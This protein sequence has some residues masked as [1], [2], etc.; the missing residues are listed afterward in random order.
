MFLCPKTPGGTHPN[1]AIS[2]WARCHLTSPCCVPVLATR[3]G[4]S[5]LSCGGATQPV[6]GRWCVSGLWGRDSYNTGS[7]SKTSLESALV[8]GGSKPQGPI[9]LENKTEENR[10]PPVKETQATPNATKAHGTPR[11]GLV[12]AVLW[13]PRPVQGTQS[14]QTKARLPLPCPPASGRT[15]RG[16]E[17]RV[18]RSPTSL[19]PAETNWGHLQVRPHHPP[20]LLP[21]TLLG[22][23]FG[24]G[25]RC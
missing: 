2:C 23:D 15:H 21:N 3:T 17:D 11:V 19:P 12:G 13:R 14:C 10:R 8:G 7:F 25:V 16:Q 20:L 5:R 9:R 6:Q 24:T 18:Q 1:D 4:S 22:E